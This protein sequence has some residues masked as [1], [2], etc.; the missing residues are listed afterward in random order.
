MFLVINLGLKSIRAIV[1]DEGGTQVYG[2]A[3]NVGTFVLDEIVEQDA[4]E[5]R[6]ELVKLLYDIK[7]NT[8]YADS[9]KYV[10]VTTSS[11]CIFGLGEDGT[12]LT[13][14]LM[15][16]DKRSFK[17]VSEIQSNILFQKLAIKPACSTSS[18]V[19]KILWFKNNKSVLFNTVKHWVGAG[20]YLAYLITGELIT[21]PLNA[22]KAFYNGTAYEKELLMG[23]GI[24]PETLPV[25]RNIGFQCE[26]SD[27]LKKLYGFKQTTKFVLTTY[28]AICS[29]VGSSDGSNEMATDVS[30]TVT[31]LRIICE[32]DRQ[33]E[34]SSET[35]LTQRI[36]L[37]NKSIIGSSNNLGGGIIE[38]FK[39]VFYSENLNDVYFE[40]EES[41]KRSVVGAGGVL[42]LP[43]LLGE[44]A[45]FIDTNTK[46]TFFGIS[47]DTMKSDFTRAAFE[48][49]AFVTRDLL[50]SVRN[51]G[52]EVNSLAV[53]GG[54]ARIHLINQIKADVC[55]VPVYV[56]DNFESTSTGAFI[57]MAIE[58]KLFSSYKDA[59]KE[60]VKFKDVI[61]PNASNNKYYESSFE[62]FKDIR[63][64]LIRF[65]S[66]NGRLNRLQVKT[67]GQT[68]INL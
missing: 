45:P 10:T 5:W 58:L 1:F 31:S 56:L 34:S 62:L 39:Q 64:S 60:I 25:V 55:N 47:R 15:V 13:K 53:S 2:K 27:E 33:L 9:I 14:V 36:E 37:I 21:D 3:F 46:G 48:S 29:V 6:T 23:L 54:L 26:V 43:Y 59:C 52:Y 22:G 67:K 44:R 19:P 68:M 63:G 24:N 17:E 32:N 42:F 57:L 12:I 7:D 20:E 65:H 38:W 41:A 30:G 61:L 16:S 11:S 4:N 51:S 50:D 35:L 18:T 66:L 49:T 28:D 40:M 8:T